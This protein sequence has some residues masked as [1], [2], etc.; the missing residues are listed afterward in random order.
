MESANANLSNAQKELLRWH[1]RLG[2]V[3]FYHI[4]WMIRVGRLKVANPKAV[5]SCAIPKC[6]SCEFG[7][8]T[9]RPTKTNT[10]VT[11]KEKEKEMELKKDDLVPGQRVSVDYYQ[12]AQPGRLFV[13][14]EQ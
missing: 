4:Q 13:Q 2:H 1:F 10:N 5:A 9:K 3:G 11:K 14:R 8:A 12:T 6:A 7:K